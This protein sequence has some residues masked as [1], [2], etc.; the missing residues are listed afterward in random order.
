MALGFFRISLNHCTTAR[1]LLHQTVRE[2]EMKVVVV[3]HQIRDLGEHSWTTDVTGSA[4]ISLL[5]LRRITISTA[6]ERPRKLCGSEGSRRILLQL[7]HAAE[8]DVKGLRGSV[9]S[10]RQRRQESECTGGFSAWT[11]ERYSKETNKR[12]QVLLKPFFILDLTLLNNAEKSTFSRGK[13]SSMINPTFLSNSLVR[14]DTSP[15]MSD[16]CTLYSGLSH[17]DI[18]VRRTDNQCRTPP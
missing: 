11:V 17:K 1:D 4:G 9:G 13:T 7:R 5:H 2:E 8:H 16:I 3:S 6:H 12:G 15:K 14:G 18:S 10:F